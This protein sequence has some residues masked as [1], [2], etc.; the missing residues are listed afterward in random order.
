MKLN[1]VSIVFPTNDLV[2]VNAKFDTATYLAVY[3]V[4]AQSAEFLH[5]AQFDTDT[6]ADQQLQ[7]RCAVTDGSSILFTFGQL[8]GLAAFHM[9]NHKVFAIKISAPEPIDTLI[10]RT[11]EM[12]QSHPPLWLQRAL[13]HQEGSKSEAKV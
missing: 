5:A 6:P 1:H 7:E 9:V 11:Q 8:S 3:D 2:T 10:K 4:S 13:N 12:I